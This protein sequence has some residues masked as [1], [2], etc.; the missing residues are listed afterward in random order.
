MTTITKL[1]DRM[2]SGDAKAQD[3]LFE[4]AYRELH[5]LA[6]HRLLA[7]GRNTDLNTTSLVHYAYM[8]FKQSGQLRAKDR[9][10]FFAY[11]ARVMRSVIVDK[12]RERLAER[13]GGDAPH[14][15]LST[16]LIESL[17]KNEEDILR[18]HEALST[19]AKADSRLGQV[20][21]MRYF[22]GYRDREVAEVLQVTERTVQRLW[23]K[24]KL[25]LQE[26]LREP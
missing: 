17:G 23:E 13:R 22:G 21:E 25:I 12:A 1:L 20:V 5:R 8:R 18:V 24:A 14:L 4:V 2:H 6:R 9:R 3:E 7:G 16:E 15:T 10:A 26:A 11:A 19:L